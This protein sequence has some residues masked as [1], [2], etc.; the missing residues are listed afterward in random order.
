MPPEVRAIR[1]RADKLL[2][3]TYEQLQLC[4]ERLAIMELIRHRLMDLAHADKKR[5]VNE[6]HRQRMLWEHNDRVRWWRDEAEPE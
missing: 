3:Q 6:F 5:L 4:E 2:H 1:D